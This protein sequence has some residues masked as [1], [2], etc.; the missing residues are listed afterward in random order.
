MHQLWFSIENISF[1]NILQSYLTLSQN[2]NISSMVLQHGEKKKNNTQSHTI[3]TK[4]FQILQLIQTPNL[5][6]I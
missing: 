3:P 2:L 4:K 5:F 6:C 1:L